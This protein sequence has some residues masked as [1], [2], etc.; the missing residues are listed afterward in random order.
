MGI[1]QGRVR[2]KQ[3]FSTLTPVEMEPISVGVER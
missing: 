2:G 1:D 3:S